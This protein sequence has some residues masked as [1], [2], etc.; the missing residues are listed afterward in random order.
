MSNNFDAA[1]FGERVRYARVAKALTQKQLADFIGVSVTQISDI[2]RG[3]STPSFKRAVSIA[4]CLDV[5]LDY[6][7]DMPSPEKV[8]DPIVQAID[9]LTHEERLLV[10]GYID[11]IKS[12]R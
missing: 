4:S 6:L 12:R 7:A 2:E 1:A 9:S 3:K 10:S 11:G 5:S 8:V